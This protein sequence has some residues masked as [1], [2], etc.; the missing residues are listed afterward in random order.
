MNGTPESPRHAISA[1]ERSIA[2][3]GRFLAS[4]S[5]L[6]RGGAKAAIAWLSVSVNLCFALLCL[7]FLVSLLSW[8][9]SDRFSRAVLFFPVGRDGR[10]EA[11]LR[12]LPRTYKAESRAELI[13]SEI[14]LGPEDPALEPDFPAG[15]GLRS[16]LY[17]KGRLFVD[18]A[19]GAALAEPE[20]L[21]RG[22]EALSLSLRAALPGIKTLTITIGGEEPYYLPPTVAAA[23]NESKKQKNN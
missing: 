12:Q 10:L 21:K 20:S 23:G 8:A 9:I 13:A 19:E 18:I 5:R 14:L 16:V 7:I 15:L 4:A 3:S 11:E 2:A 1:A 17:R 6:L 22:L